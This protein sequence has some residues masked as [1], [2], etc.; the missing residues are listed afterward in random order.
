MLESHEWTTRAKWEFREFN[1]LA[2]I[3]KFRLKKASRRAEQYLSCF[4]NYYLQPIAQFISFIFGAIAVFFLA[5]GFWDD[6]ALLQIQFIGT[7][8][9]LWCLGVCGVILAATRSVKVERKR[10][11]N[12]AKSMEKLAKHT[13]HMPKT[14]IG[15]SHTVQV[16]NQL[17]RSFAHRVKSLAQ[18]LASVILAPLVL[19]FSMTSSAVGVV[20]FFREFTETIDGLGHV[21][22]AATFEHFDRFGSNKYATNEENQEKRRT[23]THHGKMEKSM[24]NFMV[25]RWRHAVL[26]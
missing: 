3:F 6:A 25:S 13:H 4:N 20:R 5:I 9:G 17:E 14:W 16:K 23:K 15:K 10:L 26:C 7:R 21:C 2:H 24:I 11:R 1:E 18:E 12:P 8:N 19:L 22:A